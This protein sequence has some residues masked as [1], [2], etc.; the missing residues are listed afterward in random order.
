VDR[1]ANSPIRTLWIATLAVFGAAS[2]SGCSYFHGNFSEYVTMPA[3]PCLD[4]TRAV[5]ENGRAGQLAR[6]GKFDQ[7]EKAL[8]SALT[9]DV[10]NGP[11]HND[12]GYV[13]LMRGNLYYAAWEFEYAIKLMP[14][15][16]EPYYNLGTVYEAAGQLDRAIESY[17]VAHRI[18]PKN[19]QILG[20]LARTTIKKD[21]L[22]P[23][24]WS[25]LSELIL[26]DTRLP[27]HNPLRNNARLS[28]ETQRVAG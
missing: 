19:P 24:A 5:T 15:R 28:G 20:N 22:S 11:A 17:S 3:N 21:E 12:L 27:V 18:D 4:E 25:L 7:A 6:Q 10:T 14:D 16:P 8:Q 2:L 13:Y 26:C 1:S 23:Q 9:A